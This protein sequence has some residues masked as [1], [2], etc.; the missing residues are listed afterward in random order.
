MSNISVLTYYLKKCF[1]DVR[2]F[3][4]QTEGHMLTPRFLLLTIYVYQHN[5]TF[6][7]FVLNFI[8]PSDSFAQIVIIIHKNNLCKFRSHR[9]KIKKVSFL[10]G[11]IQNM[12][13]ITFSLLCS[14]LN[15]WLIPSHRLL[16][17]LIRTI[18]AS[19][20]VTGQKLKKCHS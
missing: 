13:D 9:S 14:I 4:C 19:F 5:I 16:L 6:F 10:V 20:E 18:C 8:F 17:S 15:F 7:L 12:L 2:I 3:F 1:S 11:S